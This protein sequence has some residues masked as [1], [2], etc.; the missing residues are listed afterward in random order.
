MGDAKSSLG[1]AKS[2]LGDV[3]SSLGDAKS[4][5][6]DA[7]SSLGDAKSSLGDAESR[8]EVRSGVHTQVRRVQRGQRCVPPPRLIGL[9]TQTTVGA[10]S[11]PT[12]YGGHLT[13]CL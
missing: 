7:E 4:S 10:P 9:G 6:G 1:G 8:R 13:S 5:L 12:H 2:S 11:V 3:T